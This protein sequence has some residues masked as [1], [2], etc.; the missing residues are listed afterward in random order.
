MGE[1]VIVQGVADERPKIPKDP[2]KYML[3]VENISI[4]NIRR[5][6]IG[7][8][9]YDFVEHNPKISYEEYTKEL[10]EGKKSFK[11]IFFFF[12]L[13]PNTINFQFYDRI[14]KINCN[15][16]H[17]FFKFICTISLQANEMNEDVIPIPPWTILVP[18]TEGRSEMIP[19]PTDKHISRFH[20]PDHVTQVRNDTT[21][22]LSK[23]F[24]L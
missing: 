5:A 22:F 7:W 20:I 23:D 9:A 8:S 19:I 24:D 10:A 13:L 16:Y 2:P 4:R 21:K 12:S 17:E 15:M 14:V 6:T 3:D 11:V 1:R 18:T